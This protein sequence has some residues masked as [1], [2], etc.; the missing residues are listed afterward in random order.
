[1]SRS[2]N[3]SRRLPDCASAEIPDRDATDAG[4]SPIAAGATL[5]PLVRD[6]ATGRVAAGRPEAR[7]AV[8]AAAVAVAA[9]AVLL[10]AAV[11]QAPAFDPDAPVALSPVVPADVDPALRD[12]LMARGELLLAHRLFER[13][14]WQAFV[15]LNW[16]VD[17]TGAPL[18]SLGDDGAPAWT[19]WIETY[20]V[21]RPGGAEPDPWGA[22]T[23]SLPLGDTVQ[24]VLPSQTGP[25]AYPAI[26]SGDARVLHNLS[27]VG[28]VNVADEVDQAFSFA[29]FDQNGAAVHYESLINRVEYDFIVGNRL[30][31]AGGIADHVAKTGG[32]TF[33]AGRFAGNV[34]GAIEI[35]LAWRILDPSRDDFGRYLT[36][37]AYVVSGPRSP[38]WKAVTVGLVGFHIAQKT[39]TAPQWIW[40]TFE[41]VDNLAT[42][43][44]TTITTAD[45]TT[46]PLTPSFNDPDCEWCPVNVPVD[47][48][49][50]GSRR[51]QV[52][53]LVP[54][55]PE[56]AALNRQ[57]RDALAAAGSK[58]AY[59]EMIG[60]QWPTLPQ[61]PPQSGATFPGAVVNTSGGVP[62]KAYLANSVMETFSQ[63]GNM[64][65]NRQPRSVSTSDELVFGTGSCIGCH[66]ASPY[67]FSWIITK[68]QRRAGAR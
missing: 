22:A 25:A 43:R 31:E 26:D 59:Y 53:R 58:L 11:A 47:P 65:A 24:E 55:P 13:Q 67:D 21:F 44:L 3:T 35:K 42:D 41:H 51:T 34:H 63:T 10:G 27:S 5:P 33:P 68:A 20:Q 64:P 49:P 66:G 52:Q 6:E 18:A 61:V 46:R 9:G 38:A 12:Q 28:K 14:Q 16:P 60:V 45:G 29:V 36:Q 32:V 56:T 30:F 17:K 62:L 2:R 4:C 39:E 8:L 7:R 57:M 37:P 40:S 54:I 50:D 48:G 15:A 23:R 1:M 19:R